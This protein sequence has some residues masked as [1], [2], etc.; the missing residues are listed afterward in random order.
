M[1]AG[2]FF[3]TALAVSG[4]QKLSWDEPV[5]P[6]KLLSEIVDTIQCFVVC[7]QETILAAMLWASM[8]WFIDV[9]DVAPLAIITAPEKRCG[10]SILLSILGKISCRPLLSSNISPAA[11]Y[12]SIEKWHPTLLIDEAD[13]FIKD[14]RRTKE[15]FSKTKAVF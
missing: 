3:P 5:N 14:I 11:L 15:S 6:E 10:K 8:T 7:K 4:S 2:N 9:I 12:R 1:L 13:A